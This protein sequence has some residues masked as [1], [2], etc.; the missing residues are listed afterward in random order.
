MD[1]Q[2]PEVVKF[3]EELYNQDLAA[4]ATSGYKA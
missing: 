1:S 4:F 3:D 2:T